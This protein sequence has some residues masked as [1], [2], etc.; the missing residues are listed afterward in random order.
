MQ[1]KLISEPNMFSKHLFSNNPLLPILLSSIASEGDISTQ[2]GTASVPDESTEGDELEAFEK[3]VL[4]EMEAMMKEP[5]IPSPAVPVPQVP[6][7]KSPVT[8]PVEPTPPKDTTPMVT[9]V[10]GCRVGGWAL[11]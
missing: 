10:Y 6:V 4:Q 11:A 1:L 3:E 2:S 7:E 8:R 5:P 9:G